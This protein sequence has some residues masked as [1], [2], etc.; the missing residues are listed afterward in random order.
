MPAQSNAYIFQRVIMLLNSSRPSKV[1]ENP[2]KIQ[3]ILQPEKPGG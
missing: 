2:D 3:K 1:S